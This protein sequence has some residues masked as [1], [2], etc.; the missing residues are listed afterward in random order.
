MGGREQ[1]PWVKKMMADSFKTLLSPRIHLEFRERTV[2]LLR[3]T[4][5]ILMLSLL[6]MSML[7]LGFETQTVK[8]GPRTWTVDDDGPADFSK[9]QDA[10]NAASDGDTIFVHNGTYY[11]NV[12][13]NQTVSLVGENRDN[14]IV[15]GNRT[16][17]RGTI[18]LESDNSSI[19]GFT[20]RNGEYGVVVWWWGLLPA[21]TGSRIEGNQIIDNLYGGI[22][23]RSCANNTVSDN[24]VANNTLFGIHLRSSANNIIINNTVLNNGHGIT[25][26]GD[27]NDNIL[28]NNNMTD[29]TYNFGLIL[30]GQT[31]LFAGGDRPAR[32][33]IVNDV[34]SSNTVNGKPV[35]CWDNR[36][37]EHIPADAGYVWLNECNN[38]T[39]SSCSLSN[40]LQGIL[41]L[42]SNNTSIINNNITKSAY[43]IYEWIYS[44]NNTVVGNTLEDNLNGIYLGEFTRFTTMRS[45]NI[46]GGQEAFG[47]S[48]Y[49]YQR[50]FA[51]RDLLTNDVDTSNTVNGKPI[52]Y[53]TNQHDMKVPTN[54]GY[55]ML[56]DSANILVE[57]L[58]LSN[59]VQGVFVSG[60]NSTVIAENSITNTTYGILVRETPAQGASSLWTTI[61][62]NTVT[63]NAVG[64]FILSDYTTIS[65][66]TVLRNPTGIYAVASSNFIS[67]NRVAESSVFLTDWWQRGLAQ[68]P[69]EM[70]VFYYPEVPWQVWIYGGGITIMGNGGGGNR[71]CGNIV[72]DS[73]FGGI[74][75]YS[76]S[77]ANLV[78]GNTVI[79]NNYGGIFVGFGNIVFHNNF[80]NNTP[81]QARASHLNLW[82]MGYPQG[83]NYWSDYNG[84]DVYS[85][86]YQNET[87]SDGLGDSWYVIDTLNFDPYPLMQP[88]VPISGDL[89][90]D[91]IVDI[92]DATLAALSFGS[93]PGHPRWNPEVD[94]NEDNVIDIFDIIILAINFGKH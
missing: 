36:S 30:G 91:G 23:L 25:L 28:R 88:Y 19:S 11:E 72:T 86:P 60:S 37:N 9:I 73:D 61:K 40:N 85:G 93:Y 58:N 15:D 54:A 18:W 50:E 82:F 13:V 87:G 52:V 38:I 80:I 57:G 16:G 65:N 20:V 42:F 29:N 84:T 76:D 49:E 90:Q 3:K 70:D 24:I 67:K 5:S 77:Q 34:D 4:F 71:I 17:E 56:V 33:G 75:I 12:R 83:G 10:I 55:V 47:V 92:F 2:G 62:G 78:Y 53:W 45:N 31:P 89:N 64:M 68:V 27:T 81:Y 44:N 94:L 32:H 63:D 74:T 35:Y 59:N 79:D 48:P 8:A 22:L 69:R 14:T 41:L 21:F 51:V 6:V 39:I 43:G 66:N 1:K 46:S 7:T 26:E